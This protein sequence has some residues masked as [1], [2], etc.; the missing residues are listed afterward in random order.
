MNKCNVKR[1]TNDVR[2]KMEKFLN[3]SFPSRELWII[4]NS[5]QVVDSNFHGIPI[6]RWTDPITPKGGSA[7]WLTVCRQKTRG[8][9]NTSVLPVLHLTSHI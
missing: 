8:N 4:G 9:D 5:V 6:S 1:E 7:H 2:C 3:W